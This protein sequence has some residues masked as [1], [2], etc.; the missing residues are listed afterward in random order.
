V[1]FSAARLVR[2]YVRSARFN[3]AN[4]AKEYFARPRRG[5]I[6][7][8]VHIAGAYLL[9]YAHESSWREDNRRVSNGDQ[10]KRAAVTT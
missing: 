10:V 9:R 8:H 3:S 5:E 2:S 4:W 6:S 7:N 1:F